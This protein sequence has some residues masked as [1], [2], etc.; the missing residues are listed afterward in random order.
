MSCTPENAPNFWFILKIWHSPLTFPPSKMA[1][2]A[3]VDGRNPAPPGMQNTLQKYW[4]LLS[5]LVQDFSDQQYV[6]YIFS[7]GVS[8]Q[9]FFSITQNGESRPWIVDP[10]GYSSDFPASWWEVVAFRSWYQLGWCKLCY[11]IRLHWKHVEFWCIYQQLRHHSWYRRYVQQKNLWFFE[12]MQ[13]RN[14]R[15]WIIS[16]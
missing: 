2:L 6:T 5:Q 14:F 10:F 12:A 4:N 7:F 1:C 9:P 8:F 16:I 15:A 11:I 13:F 3:T